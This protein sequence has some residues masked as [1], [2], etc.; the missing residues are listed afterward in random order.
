[1]SEYFTLAELRERGWSPT[2]IRKMLDPP[3][4]LRPNPVF[5]SASP[6]RLYET[7]RVM[8][9]ERSESFAVL[10]AGATRQSEAAKA[11]AERR[12]GET[13]AGV[14]EVRIAIPVLEWDVL[15][16]RAVDHRNRRDA[17]RAWDRVDHI[18]KPARLKEVDG[19]TLRRWMVNYLRHN[20]TAYDAELG[21][22]F[23]KVGRAEG[24]RLL[25]RR[26]YAAIAEAYSVLA[27][28]CRRQL[29]ERQQQTGEDR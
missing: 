24:S 8:L 17:E 13:L 1:M 21:Q 7:E 2:M 20:L 28:E 12:R 27:E 26:I 25:Q 9:A 22:L 4:L 16:R 6:M 19:P 14:E 18:P 10:R 11:A 3:D 15:A 29:H 5:R 23:G